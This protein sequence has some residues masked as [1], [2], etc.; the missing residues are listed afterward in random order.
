[1]TTTPAF[2]GPRLARIAEEYGTPAWVYDA[3]HIR[4]QIAR[5][6][7]FDVIRFAQKACSNTHILR[8]MRAEGVLVDAVSQGELERA[9]TA[10]YQ[11]DGPNEPVVFTADLLDRATLRRVVELGVP[12][13]A[14]SPQMLDQ[15]GSASPG[16]PV[17]I[18]STPAS[19]TATAARP[20]PAASTASTASGTSTWPTASSWSTGTG[21]T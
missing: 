13:N 20:T 5:L 11:V 6:R 15:V 10:G 18:G 14:G 2:D 19:G 8:L 4:A 1:M 3:A 12:V 9:L 7:S 21:W 16:H 17:W